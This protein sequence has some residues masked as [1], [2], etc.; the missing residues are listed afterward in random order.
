[1]GAGGEE[2]FEDYITQGK[3]GW[4]GFHHA[5]LLGDFRRLSDGSAV[6][7]AKGLPAYVFMGSHR[8]LFDSLRV[9]AVVP[10][11]DFWGA[12]K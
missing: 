9:R 1:L 10:N 8:G 4:I 7:L 2:G 11:C 12:G 5:G 3:G 6:P